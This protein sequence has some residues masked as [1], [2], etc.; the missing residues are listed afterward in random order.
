MKTEM[1]PITE[2]LPELP[3]EARRY[4]IALSLIFATIALSGLVVGI[5][6]PRSYISSTTILA[7]S[8]DII[9]PLLEGRAVATGVVDRTGMARQVIFSRKVLEDALTVGGW[10]EERPSALMQD[11][12]M[13]QIKGR[14]IIRSPRPELIQIT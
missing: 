13:E 6:W 11:R 12:L 1:A 2:M 10:M 7:Q 8:S 4:S 5:L 14:T 9:Q 3:R